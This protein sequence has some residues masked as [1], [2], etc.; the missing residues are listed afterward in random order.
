MTLQMKENS[1][2]TK[3]AIGTLKSGIEKLASIK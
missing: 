1:S 2:N 3:K